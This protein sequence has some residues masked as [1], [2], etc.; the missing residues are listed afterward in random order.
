MKVQERAKLLK[1]VKNRFI[2]SVVKTNNTNHHA[3]SDM[4]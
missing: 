3:K 4:F 2:A 1:R